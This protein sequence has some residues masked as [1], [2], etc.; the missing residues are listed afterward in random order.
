MLEGGRNNE[1]EGGEDGETERDSSEQ[2]HGG[3]C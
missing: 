3:T 1:R 2:D